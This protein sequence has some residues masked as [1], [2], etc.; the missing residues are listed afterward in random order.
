MPC[1]LFTFHAYGS[2]LPDHS[3][4]FV[5]RKEGVQP[6]NVALAK[7]YRQRMTETEVT[8][9]EPHQQTT[10]EAIKNAAKHIA[11]RLHFISTET[12]HLHLLTSWHDEKTW[13]Q[14]RNSYKRAI[15]ITLQSEFAKRTW[16]SEGSSRKCVEDHEHFE[17]LMTRYLPRHR[18]WKWS[19]HKGLFKT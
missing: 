2:W 18:G 7:T 8:L 9:A 4:G 15:T 3:K 10:I 13:Q 14:K 16:L 11:C 19:E 5:L 12:T 1:Y 6:T 17:Y